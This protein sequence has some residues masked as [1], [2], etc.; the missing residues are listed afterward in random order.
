[1]AVTWLYLSLTLSRLG[2]R[3]LGMGAWG[4]TLKVYKVFTKIGR[5]PW[6]RRKLC[7]GPAGVI[8]CTPLSTLSFWVSLFPRA[9]GYNNSIQSSHSLSSPSPPALNWVPLKLG[10]SAEFMINISIQNI[11]PFHVQNLFSSRLR[12]IKEVREE[13]KP[14]V[15]VSWGKTQTD[16]ETEVP[17]LWPPDVKNWLIGKDGDTEKD[18]SQEEKGLKDGWMAS[19]TQWTWIWISSRSW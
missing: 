18:W 12:S 7:L 6:L 14:C 9:F 8:N 4:H 13:L 10:S 19:L 16:A 3:N 1:M 15:H 5:G 2:L 17:I 11:N